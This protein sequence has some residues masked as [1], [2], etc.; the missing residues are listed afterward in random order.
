MGTPY[1]SNIA[2]DNIGVYKC[3]KEGILKYISIIITFYRFRANKYLFAAEVH[4][5]MVKPKS[6]FECDFSDPSSCMVTT[7]STT[8][9]ASWKWLPKQFLHSIVQNRGRF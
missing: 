8:A 2:L 4:T 9:H 7:R 1:E 5:D 3:D 6:S